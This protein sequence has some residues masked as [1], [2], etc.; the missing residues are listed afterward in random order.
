MRLRVL[1]P[2][3]ARAGGQRV[4]LG[5]PRQRAVLG[6]LAVSPAELVSRETIIDALWGED[7]WPRR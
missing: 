4:G 1:G 6:L 2:L 7:R 3:E 5:P